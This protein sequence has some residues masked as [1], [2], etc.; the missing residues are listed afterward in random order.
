[1]SHYDFALLRSAGT[2]TLLVSILL[3]CGESSPTLPVPQVH[4][5]AMPSATSFTVVDLGTFQ[6]G[7]YSLANA[8]NDHGVIVGTA[9][10]NGIA[11]GFSMTNG[12]I[13]SLGLLPGGDFASAADINNHDVIVGYGSAFGT[14]RWYPW[15]RRHQPGA[16]TLE[17]LPI[18]RRCTDDALATSINNFGVIVGGCYVGQRIHALRWD[19]R[20]RVSDIHPPRFAESRA[21]SVNDRG[22]VVGFVITRAGREFAF[23]W[24]G[25][26][27]GVILGSLGGTRSAAFAV[28]DSSAIVGEALDGGGIPRAFLHRGTMVDIGAGEAEAYGISNPGRI[29]G[30]RVTPDG[31]RA[32][33]S[34]HGSHL[35]L[36]GL[37]GGGVSYAAGINNCGKTVGY[38]RNA[39]NQQRAVLW[40]PDACDTG[41]AFP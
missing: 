8:I 39:A 20:G 34:R 9:D 27:T 18:P 22:Q 16:D 35:T 33:S 12:V 6:T 37:I 17:F 31:R 15:K 25:R 3:A 2:T 4:T 30:Q 21:T 1:M 36:P 29:V 13:T 26:R 14:A 38:A 32:F 41:P 5:D 28:N 40:V 24:T 10:S 11:R 7:V 23:R 19:R